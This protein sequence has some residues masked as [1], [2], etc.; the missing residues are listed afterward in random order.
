MNSWM[1]MAMNYGEYIELFQSGFPKQEIIWGGRAAPPSAPPVTKLGWG[2]QASPWGGRGGASRKNMGGP[3]G[4]SRKRSVWKK[5]ALYMSYI[6]LQSILTS[7][8]HQNK[9][10]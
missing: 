6:Q 7:G 1:L 5:M 8:I 2:G 9:H 3:G 10:W 4:P